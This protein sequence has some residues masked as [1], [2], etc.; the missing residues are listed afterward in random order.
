MR[1][2]TVCSLHGGPVR[3]DVVLARRL[4]IDSWTPWALTNMGAVRQP[5]SYSVPTWLPPPPLTCRLFSNSSTGSQVTLLQYTYEYMYSYSST[6]LCNLYPCYSYMSTTLQFT[7]CG[8][9]WGNVNWMLFLQYLSA[10]AEYIN[11]VYA[12]VHALLTILV[13]KF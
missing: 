6:L 5:Y 2:P 1:Q 12:W 13:S 9:F 7:L 10:Y 8:E 4:G 3:Q 11:C